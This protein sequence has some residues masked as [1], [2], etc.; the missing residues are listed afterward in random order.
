MGVAWRELGGG[1]SKE[2]EEDKETEGEGIR[3]EEK[4]GG[5]STDS[6]PNSTIPES[7]GKGEKEKPGL[8]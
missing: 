1:G 2:E 6:L 3:V 5:G 8:E 4:G 7:T